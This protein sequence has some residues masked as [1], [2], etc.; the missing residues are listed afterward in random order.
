MLFDEEYTV[1]SE[2]GFME[3]VVGGLPIENERC[4]CIACALKHSDLTG[5][6]KVGFNKALP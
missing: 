2:V 6:G 4:R 1:C 5:M 3:P